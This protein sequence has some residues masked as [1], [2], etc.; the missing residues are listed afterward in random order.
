MN[1]LLIV[2]SLSLLSITG[3]GQSDTFIAGDQAPLFEALDYLGEKIELSE[4]LKAGPVVLFF[5]RGSWCS[6]CTRQMKEL[7]DSVSMITG[8]GASIIGITP[9]TN[10]SI[11]KIAERSGASFPLIHDTGYKIMKQY[12]VSFRLDDETISRYRKYDLGVAQ[13]NDNEDYIL[14][15][16]ATYVIDTDGI[17]RFIYFNSDYRKRVT[18]L[19]ILKHL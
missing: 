1:K 3:S 9:E 14:P 11:I 18:V 6:Y 12:N 16:P 5:Y 19:E 2:F 10:N 7:Q 15:V 4:K 17:I 13:S 8:K